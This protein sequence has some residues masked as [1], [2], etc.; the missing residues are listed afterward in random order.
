MESSF[1]KKQFIEYLI[2]SRKELPEFAIR[3]DDEFESGRMVR[4]TI[5]DFR[6]HFA[7]APPI[8]RTAMIQPLFDRKNG[9]LAEP[10]I[11]EDMYKLILGDNY[12]EPVVRRLFDS[13]LNN[14]PEAEEKVILSHII[15]SFVDSPPGVK[16][17]SLKT[18][19]EAMGLWC[20]GGTISVDK[21]STP[22]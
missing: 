10:E 14:I 3:L 22:R 15:S 21:W 18:V 16:G 17:A 11:Q 7:E 19:L 8:A 1:D 6:S 13:Y 4:D 9:I 20:Q 12:R 5:K 2:G